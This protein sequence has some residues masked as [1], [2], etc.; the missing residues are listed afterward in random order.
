MLVI[1]SC[2][3]LFLANLANWDFSLSS[4]EG[5]SFLEQ[6]QHDRSNAA[7]AILVQLVQLVHTACNGVH[8]VVEQVIMQLAIA[9]TELLLLEE[10]TIVHERQSVEDVKLEALGEDEGVVDELVE[11]LLESRLVRRLLQTGF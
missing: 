9:G 7:Q 5:L 11:A 1:E 4:L 6:L 10:Q 8:P 2:N 3:R